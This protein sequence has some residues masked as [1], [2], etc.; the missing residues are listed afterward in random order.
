VSAALALW[1]YAA[2]RADVALE[3]FLLGPEV[4]HLYARPST[5]RARQEVGTPRSTSCRPD[6]P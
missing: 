5:R 4:E 3:H 1:R 2:W 6:S